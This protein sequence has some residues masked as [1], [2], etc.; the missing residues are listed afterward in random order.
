[1]LI[2]YLPFFMAELKEME[3]LMS[4][5][6]EFLN[7]DGKN[8]QVCTNGVYSDQYIKGASEERTGH[9]E[10][11]LN[12]IPKLTDTLDVRQFRL[13]A[14]YNE[15]LPYTI[16]K[17][18]ESLEVLCG[19]TGYSTEVFHK[20]YRLKVRIALE[21]KKMFDEAAALIERMV[22]MNMIIDLS[23]K[24]NQHDTLRLLTHN[25]LHKFKHREVREE[26]L[27]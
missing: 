15:K 17:L 3:I 22:P 26:V 5:G 25:Y 6:D 21:S 10:K 7:G 23:L 16:R 27:S 14:R 9:Y 19:E 4:I 13:L 1:M 18:N 11:M 24:Y 2:D 12:I 8:I 20:E